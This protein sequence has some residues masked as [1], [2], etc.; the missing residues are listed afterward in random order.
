MIMFCRPKLVYLHR[1]KIFSNVRVLCLASFVLVACRTG[2]FG[3]GWQLWQLHHCH[4]RTQPPKATTR[5]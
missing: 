3:Y 5:K 1:K 2:E 4:Q